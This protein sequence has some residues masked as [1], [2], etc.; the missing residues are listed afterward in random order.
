MGNIRILADS[1]CDLSK[2]LL[3]KYK[4][5]ITPLYITIGDK[6]GKDGVEITPDEI[7]K[8]ADSNNDTPKTS[9]FTPDDAYAI[10]KELKENDEEGIFIGISEDMS[11]A[12]NVLR[13]AA[14]DAE[15]EDKIHVINSMNLST[16]IGLLVLSAIDMA[17]QG[18]SASEIVKEIEEL[19]PK[20]RASFVIDTLTYLHRGG[21]CSAATALVANTLRLK[22]KIIV[23]NG[24]M[25]VESKYRGK[26]SAVV[27][28]YVRD[29]EEKLINS[30]KE[31]VF[32]THSGIDNEV[33]EETRLYLEGLNHFNEIIE[34]RAGGV[35]SSHCG[36]GT[37]GVLFIEN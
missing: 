14:K 31:R 26:Q 36:P 15:Y 25:D 16:G 11:C 22:P 29:M 30:K 5:N 37:L 20:V 35:V 2:D 12:C 10:I 8:W 33:V 19:R 6:T 23:E 28:K 4:I 9:A 34:T 24:K 3:D 27:K 13:L 7:Y 1:T 18:K 32:I 17:G 21:R